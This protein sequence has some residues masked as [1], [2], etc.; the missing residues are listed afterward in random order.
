[1]STSVPS[2][3]PQAGRESTQ[4]M[5]GQSKPEEMTTLDLTTALAASSTSAP[6]MTPPIVVKGEQAV[7]VWQNDK[8]I[9][10]I[11]AI[12]EN[13]NIWLSVAGVG[14]KKLANNSDS[15]VVALN[16]LAT[17]AR[18]MNSPVNYREEADGMLHELYV[19]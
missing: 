4:A 2:K 12:N 3:M 18:Q 13:R 7:A 8:R 19:W 9:N 16:M 15:A 14:W 6:M 10:A 17:H 11:W 5:T 1:M